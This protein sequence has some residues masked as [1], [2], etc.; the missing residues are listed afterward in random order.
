MLFFYYMDKHSLKIFYVL[1]KKQQ[2][3]QQQK[4]QKK[5]F[6]WTLLNKHLLVA[7]DFYNIFSILCK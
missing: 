3:Q 2:Q 6:W 5:I 1:Q 7:I 4:T